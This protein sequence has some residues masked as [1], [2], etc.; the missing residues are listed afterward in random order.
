MAQEPLTTTKLD[1]SVIQDRLALANK[2][3]QERHD[4]L[5]HLFQQ[6]GCDGGFS[7]QSYGKWSLPNLLCTLK[8]EG[9]ATILVGAHYDT[10]Q[11]SQGVV[12]NWSG[13]ALL[14][15]LFQSLK[16][17]PRKHTFLFVSFSGQEQRL[18]G[19]RYFVY[20][21]HAEDR[22]HLA[23]IV[24]LDSLGL[25]ATNV[26]V[27]HSDKQLAQWL[28]AVA[29]SLKL[30]LNPVEFPRRMTTDSESFAD[31]K[32]PRIAISSIDPSSFRILHSGAGADQMSI[33]KQDE[34]Y[35][36][37]HLLSVYLAYLDQKL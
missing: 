26:W 1:A 5:V 29:N 11:R 36:T 24:D 32:V 21:L 3:N 17:S 9:S 33:V 10:R 14:P 6:A 4:V 25:A 35:K 23:A 37:Y 22:K 12:D 18:V 20:Y 8:G 13:A 7:E 31:L 28:I 2:N 27:S 16:N 30:P 19:S 34:Y 15:S